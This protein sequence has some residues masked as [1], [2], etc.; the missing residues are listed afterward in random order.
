MTTRFITIDSLSDAFL[1]PPIF[2]SFFP[3]S[4]ADI[5]WPELKTDGDTAA[6]QPLPARRTGGAG[7]A[8]G[9]EFSD[10]G[11]GSQDGD[12]MTSQY[13][14]GSIVTGG[15]AGAGSA[16]I[17]GSSDAYHQGQGG[18]G[19]DY[20]GNPRDSMTFGGSQIALSAGAGNSGYPLNGQSGPGYYEDG[21]YA[22]QPHYGNGYEVGQDYGNGNGTYEV[23]QDYGNG[24]AAYG[25]NDQH[26]YAPQQHGEAPMHNP[27]G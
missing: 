20:G 13:H 12:Q 22:P 4:S 16:A 1:E 9:D 15:I 27:Y 21:G 17:Y 5:K 26:H 18:E 24:N 8:M 11:H 6:M 14:D 2:L 7:F 3:L 25:S 10:N 23:G 19:M